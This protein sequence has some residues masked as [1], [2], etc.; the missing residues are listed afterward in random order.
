MQELNL[1]K[2]KVIATGVVGIIIR[3]SKKENVTYYHLV[4]SEADKLDVY[5]SLGKFKIEDLDYTDEQK[6]QMWHENEEH[7]RQVN[8]DNH[9]HYYNR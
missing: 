1:E 3:E 8:E 2:K 7:G 9:E 5:I 4:D 6:E